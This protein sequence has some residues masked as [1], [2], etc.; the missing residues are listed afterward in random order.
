MFYAIIKTTDSNAVLLWYGKHWH[1]SIWKS[2]QGVPEERY[3]L[4]TEFKIL[5]KKN[6]VDAN[7]KLSYMCFCK[8]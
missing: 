4:N 8:K 7:H 1:K 5:G 3:V 6:Y 2:L